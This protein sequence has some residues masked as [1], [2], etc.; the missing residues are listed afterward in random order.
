M[1]LEQLEKGAARADRRDERG[2]VHQRQVG[3]GEFA[4]LVEQQRTEAFEQLAAARRGRRE[5]M[6]GAARQQYQMSR[7]LLGSREAERL[8]HRRGLVRIERRPPSVLGG[9]GSRAAAAM[10]G[11]AQHLAELRGDQCAMVL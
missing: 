7:A 9:F 2:E 5:R 3:I 6:F 10:L 1:L 4:N 11:G 8:Q